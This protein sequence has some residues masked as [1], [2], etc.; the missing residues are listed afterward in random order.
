MLGD[1]SNEIAEQSFALLLRQLMAFS[2]RMSEMLECNGTIGFRA[3]R[4]FG[5]HLLFLRERVMRLQQKALGDSHSEAKQYQA[6]FDAMSLDIPIFRAF[7]MTTGPGI[8]AGA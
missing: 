1:H 6:F 3:G 2:K 8:A 4:F 5:S 7:L